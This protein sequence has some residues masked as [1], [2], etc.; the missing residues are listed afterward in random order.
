MG[1]LGLGVGDEFPTV[2]VTRDEDGVVHH[3]HY[4]RRPR[5]RLLRIVLWCVLISA[6]FRG[7]DYGFNDHSR[8]WRTD[9]PWSWGPW[10]AWDPF[11]P[12]GGIAVTILI[13]GVA[14]WLLWCR[15][16]RPSR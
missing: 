5:G 11:F 10:G 15:D 12:F 14:L 8:S 7:L 3:H 4:Y 9:G 13:V 6:L 16:N 2:E 1:K